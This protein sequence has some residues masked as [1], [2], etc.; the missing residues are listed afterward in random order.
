M[1]SFMT[2]AAGKKY[3]LRQINDRA[4]IIVVDPQECKIQPLPAKFGTNRLQRSNVSLFSSHL[5]TVLL[6]HF[7]GYDGCTQQCLSTDIG[8]WHWEPSALSLAL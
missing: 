6:W 4:S 8:A 7:V 3:R 2:E 5:T 1:R